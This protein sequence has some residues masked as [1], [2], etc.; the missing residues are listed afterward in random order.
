M[1]GIHYD[2][3]IIINIQYGNVDERW[4]MCGLSKDDIESYNVIKD[5]ATNRAAR[6]TAKNNPQ[7][8]PALDASSDETAIRALAAMSTKET[9]IYLCGH[10][11]DHDPGS[12]TDIYFAGW[13]VNALATR[14]R[15]WGV[16]WAKRVILYGCKGH[17]FAQAFHRALSEPKLGLPAVYCEV[18][19][20][21]GPKKTGKSP[22]F[23]GRSLV[24]DRNG[25]LAPLWR[26]GDA[27]TLSQWNEDVPLNSKI[28]YYWDD[29]GIQRFVGVPDYGLRPMS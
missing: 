1:P 23:R 15:G 20:F 2:R 26:H 17:Y 9:R 22:D 5:A 10:G 8:S 24:H 11:H 29:N 19:A 6:L 14:L 12:C 18:A 25:A 16:K 7:T 3:T 27:I 4:G 13:T 21:R 28:V